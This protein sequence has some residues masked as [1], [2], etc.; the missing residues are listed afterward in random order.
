M[1]IGR[2]VVAQTGVPQNLW[3]GTPG[4]AVQRQPQRRLVRTLIVIANDGNT[5]IVVLAKSREVIAAA[6]TRQGLWAMK[7]GETIYIDACESEM[8]NIEDWY[9]D[10]TVAGEG[11]RW[12]GFV[13]GVHSRI[14]PL[15]T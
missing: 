11:I 5:G 2:I 13:C 6:A 1:P 8:I 10:A 12:E 9:V 7:A 14:E 3:G 15:A 4:V